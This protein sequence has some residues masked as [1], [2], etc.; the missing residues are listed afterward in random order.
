VLQQSAAFST[1]L[2]CNSPCKFCPFTS[3]IGLGEKPGSVQAK[4]YRQKEQKER[5]DEFL[6]QPAGK[7]IRTAPLL[8]ELHRAK[9]RKR[10]MHPEKSPG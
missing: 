8:K 10:K 3:H 4:T 5:S 1:S 6:R 9:S 7:K 2:S